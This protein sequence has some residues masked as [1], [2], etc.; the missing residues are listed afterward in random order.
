MHPSQER[1]GGSAPGDGRPWAATKMLSEGE[2]GLPIAK[3]LPFLAPSGAGADF[4][5]SPTLLGT[6]RTGNRRLSR[7][8]LP[9]KAS[10]GSENP[11]GVWGTSAWKFLAQSSESNCNIPRLNIKGWTFLRGLPIRFHAITLLL[12]G[13]CRKAAALRAWTGTRAN[14]LF[15]R[16][17]SGISPTCPVVDFW[18]RARAWQHTLPILSNAQLARR[19]PALPRHVHVNLTC[20]GLCNDSPPCTA[21]KSRCDC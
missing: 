7:T 6:G 3:P 20:D 5:G 11:M 10:A 18:T 13:E 2:E 16:G 9:R 19:L 1:D 17:G 14:A 8:E 4:E 12:Q 21:V 15:K